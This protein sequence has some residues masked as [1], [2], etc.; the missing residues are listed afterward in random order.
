MSSRLA[1]ILFTALP[2]T[3][4]ACN[5]ASTTGSET[6]GAGGSGGSGTGGV[7]ETTSTTK[8]RTTPDPMFLP[9]VTGAC[10]DFTEGTITVSPDGKSRDLRLWI[11]DAAASLDGPIVFFWHGVGGSPNDALYALGTPVID[12]IKA[13]GGMV[14]APVHDPDAG[15]F[16]WYLTTGGTN[17]SDIRVM[18]EAL[19]CAIQKVGVDLRH[20]HST[21]FSAGAMNTTQ[22]GWWRSGYIASV[23][24]FSG[25]QIGT[26]PDQDP[27]NKFPAMVV[28]GGAATSS[29]SSSAPER[30]VRPSLKDEGHFAFICDH[31]KGHTVPTDIRQPAWQFLQDHP[32]GQQ[33]EPYAEALPAGFPSYCSL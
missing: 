9:A 17:D 27:E 28:H 7:T 16:P 23:V 2:L 31:G 29:S 12:E 33:P 8:D 25:A 21:G 5:S 32:F 3:L 20:I 15:T 4:A 14:I 13:L 19:A 26:P 1:S 10:P 11:S 30:E 6:A 18:D 24:T 22:V